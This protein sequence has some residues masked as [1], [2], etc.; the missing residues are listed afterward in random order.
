AHEAIIVVPVI[1]EELGRG[2]HRDGELLRLPPLPEVVQGVPKAHGIRRSI[3]EVLIQPFYLVR[4]VFQAR[5]NPRTDLGAPVSARNLTRSEGETSWLPV[6][7]KEI[8]VRLVHEGLARCAEDGRG[9]TGFEEL[10]L[11]SIRETIGRR[12]WV[13]RLAGA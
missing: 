1:L 6:P 5:L 11:E 7:S 8:H 9:Q 10:E 13:G 4:S 3:E 2:K 12:G